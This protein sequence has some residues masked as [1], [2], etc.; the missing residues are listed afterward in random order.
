MTVLATVFAA[1]DAISLIDTNASEVNVLGGSPGWLVRGFEVE[2]NDSGT[3]WSWSQ[4]SD[5]K[6]N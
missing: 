3:R 6:F 2:Y 4:T 5:L 1:D